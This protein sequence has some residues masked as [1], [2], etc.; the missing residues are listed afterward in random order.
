MSARE[1]KQTLPPANPFLETSD[2]EA[3]SE[4]DWPDGCDDDVV[5]ANS[6]LI[7]ELEQILRGEAEA[8]E[9]PAEEAPDEDE[10]PVSLLPAEPEAEPETFSDN[11]DGWLQPADPAMMFDDGAP[12]APFESDPEPLDDLD[13]GYPPAPRYGSPDAPFWQGAGLEDDD[14]P[15]RAAEARLVR[16]RDVA[17]ITVL[18]ALIASGATFSAIQFTREPV[19]VASADAAPAPE[20]GPAQAT[21]QQDA[22]EADPPAAGNGGADVPE[23][24]LVDADDAPPLGENIGLAEAATPDPVGPAPVEADPAAEPPSV[25][26]AAEPQAV[27]DEPAETPARNAIAAE[28]AQEPSMMAFADVGGPLVRDPLEALSGIPPE[29]AGGVV[30]P[31]A[32]DA[33]ADTTPAVANSYVNMRAGP[34]NEAAIITVVAE[35]AD[36]AVVECNFWC[37]VIVDGQEGWIYQDFLDLQP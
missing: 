34:D 17:I 29:S 24:I 13:D 15:E 27:A 28:D 37:E 1:S 36:V 23:P 16:P 19:V 31:G 25:A 4:G 3:W 2:P 8:T 35:G 20:P 6:G 18:V 21:P 30:N 7:D 33:P 32:G 26:G 5:D 11:G 9:Q 22:G 10:T 12:E 14:A